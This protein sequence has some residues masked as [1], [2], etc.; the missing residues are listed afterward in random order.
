MEV[1]YKHEA[2]AI[3][4]NIIFFSMADVYLILALVVLDIFF[5]DENFSISSFDLSLT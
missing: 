5:F 3:V 2:W 4:V 1:V